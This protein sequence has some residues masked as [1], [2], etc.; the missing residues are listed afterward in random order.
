MRRFALLLGL[1]VFVGVPAWAQND[2]PKV[3]LFA[4]YSY[5][6]TD[7]PRFVN[8]VPRMHGHGWTLSISGNFHKYFGLSGD[9]AGQYGQGNV[10]AFFEMP[11]RLESREISFSN[12]QFLF[13]PRITGRTE[14]VNAFAHALFGAFYIRRSGFFVPFFP[15]SS[16]SK[17]YFAMG[18]GGGLDINASRHLAVRVFQVDYIPMRQRSGRWLQTVRAQA[19][20][21]VKFGG[22]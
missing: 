19:G 8:R 10:Q 3:E 7:L 4:G 22:W 18:F 6:N 16:S 1:M 20:I 11:G 9:F 2:Y 21:V 17:T 12:H 14:R 13:G 5:A 15:V